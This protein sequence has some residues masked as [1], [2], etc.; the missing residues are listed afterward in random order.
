MAYIR[1]L[2]FN[3]QNEA[4][5]IFQRTCLV[6]WKKFEQYDETKNFAAWACQMAYFE[7]LKQRD[8]K[9][10]VMLLSDVALEAL[11][12]AATPIAMQVNDRRS[13]LAECMKR[14]EKDDSRLVHW[15]YFDG[16]SV[17]EIAEQAKRSTHAIYRELS[18]LHGNLSRC[19]QAALQ[20]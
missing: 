5:E 20:D 15:R 17:Q 3:D 2:V 16:L 8:A 6:L 18:R 14:L 13:A 9:R 12:E 7:V 4:D 11:S 19:I 10:K 1:I